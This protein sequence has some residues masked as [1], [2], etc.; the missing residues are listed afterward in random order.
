[1]ILS[2]IFD[3]RFILCPVVIAWRR[4]LPVGSCDCKTL[5]VFGFRIATWR[6]DV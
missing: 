2:P 5:Y 4:F 6:V 1:M 3:I